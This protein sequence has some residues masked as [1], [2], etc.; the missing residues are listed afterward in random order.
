MR[1]FKCQVCSQ[2]LYFENSRCGSCGHTLGY[3]PNRNGLLALTADGNDWRA[4]DETDA[5]Y[6]FC[7]NSIHGVCNWLVDS[8]SDEI[9]C[10]ACRHNGIIPDLS[11]QAN[12]DNWRKIEAAKHRL[13]YT[14]LRLKLPIETRGENPEGLIFNFLADSP[15][16]PN[17]K[18]LTGHDNGLITLALAEA[19]DVERER[20]RSLM[21]EPYRTLLG[22]FRHEVGHY[23]W[24][25]LVRDEGH[26]QDFIAMFGDHTHDYNQALHNHYNQGAP[27]DWQNHFVSAYATSHPWEDFAESW[28]HYLHIVDTLEMAGAFSLHVEPRIDLS[29]QLEAT[30]DFD[31]Y[32]VRNFKD[33]VDSWLPMSFALNNINRCMGQPDFYP[34]ILSPTVIAKLG[35]IHNLIRTQEFTGSIK[36]AEPQPSGRTVEAVQPVN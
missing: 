16:D 25:R 27:P 11:Q 15:F 17:A 18:V 7:A 1:L 20:R 10:L 22:H 33:V 5:A 19:D 32:R 26:A 34:F 36:P 30:I 6:R 23:Y 14:L 8:G 24:D 28:A 13:I 12:A 4:E 9:Y 2:L 29:G 35:Y 21:G 31:P 3:E